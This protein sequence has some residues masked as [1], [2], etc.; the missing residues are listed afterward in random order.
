MKLLN[1]DKL[2]KSLLLDNSA[3]IE[4]FIGQYITDNLGS[5]NSYDL[6]LRIADLLLDL[7]NGLPELG[8]TG[9]F[10]I[11]PLGG[12]KYTLVLYDLIENHDGELKVM[13]KTEFYKQENT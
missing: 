4:E 12:G 9:S 10:D 8:I 3:T 6:I 1:Y 13:Y 2:A 7:S 5:V 11:N